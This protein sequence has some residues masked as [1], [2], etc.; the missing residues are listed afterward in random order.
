MLSAA[1]FAS[2]DPPEAL[3]NKLEC[4]AL[5]SPVMVAL[6]SEEDLDRISLLKNLRCFV[7]SLLNPS[8]LDSL[9]YGFT[10]CNDGN[11]SNSISNCNSS[12]YNKKDV[13]V[14]KK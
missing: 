11:H 2:V 5:A 8:G 9:L 12:K 3:Q 6:S 4:L 14:H 13:S 10:G 7:G 1:F